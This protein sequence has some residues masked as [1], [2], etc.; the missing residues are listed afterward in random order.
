MIE[1][2][3][4]VILALKIPKILANDNRNQDS[5]EHFKI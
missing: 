4:K 3:T 2:I 1:I 5:I